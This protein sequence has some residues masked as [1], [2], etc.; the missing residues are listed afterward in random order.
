MLHL[1]NMN[2]EQFNPLGS[3]FVQPE[4]GSPLEQDFASMKTGALHNSQMFDEEGD[5]HG[6]EKVNSGTGNANKNNEVKYTDGLNEIEPPASDS[7]DAM[8][9]IQDPSQM[10]IEE[11]IRTQTDN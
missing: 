9:D 4:K 6:G 10:S 1:N 7:T 3:I 8:G 11:L 5:A 2:R